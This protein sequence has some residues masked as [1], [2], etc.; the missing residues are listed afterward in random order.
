MNNNNVTNIKE[1]LEV[2]R[3]V[4]I[5]LDDNNV[6]E[7]LETLEMKSYL[8]SV[9]DVAKACEL[10]VSTD[11]V[12]V[13]ITIVAINYKKCEG[14]IESNL[15]SIIESPSHSLFLTTIKMTPQFHQ[16]LNITGDSVCYS[17]YLW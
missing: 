3:G 9:L 5:K 4:G 13:A 15:H 6:E 8:K 11:K 7:A 12:K 10:D 14:Q 2:I 16:L 17:K 1:M